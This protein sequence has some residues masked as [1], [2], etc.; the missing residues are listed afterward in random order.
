VVVFILGD[1]SATLRTEILLSS[2]EAAGLKEDGPMIAK[3]LYCSRH[4][5]AGFAAFITVVSLLDGSQ[6]FH[7]SR[8]SP[9]LVL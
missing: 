4:W 5:Q 8:W 6:V 1:V 3:D 9:S 7:A 2:L